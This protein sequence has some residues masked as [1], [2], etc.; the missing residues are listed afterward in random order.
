MGNFDY[1]TLDPN[2]EVTYKQK[3]RVGAMF[4]GTGFKKINDGD[5]PDWAQARRVVAVINEYH[6]NVSGE[7]LT[8]KG[9]QK[10][11][12]AKTLPKHYRDLFDETKVGQNTS[13]TPET[14]TEKGV[15]DISNAS[16]EDLDALQAMINSKR[17]ESEGSEE[18]GQEPFDD[19][20]DL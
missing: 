11:L 6:N 10:V 20:A 12:S 15:I 13:K 14:A 9:M 5:K 3:M 17:K 19:V 8:N 4:S 18:S 16:E 2:K 1:T 7:P